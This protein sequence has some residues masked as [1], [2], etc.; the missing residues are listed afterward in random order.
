[1]SQ[2][3]SQTIQAPSE[4]L[5]EAASVLDPLESQASPEGLAGIATNT[6]TYA[7]VQTGGKQYRMEVGR[8]YDIE[9]LSASPDEAVTLTEVL[10]INQGG[11]VT[12]GQPL[13]AGATVQGRVVD[14]I[15][16]KKVLVYKMKP[17]KKTRKKNGHRQPLT[18][19]MVDHITPGAA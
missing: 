13:V 9:L 1:M 17:K 12:V 15:K 3:E 10:L 16:A 8:F 7:I 11:T 18:R 6:S 2:E 5:P 14:H 4:A 19:F